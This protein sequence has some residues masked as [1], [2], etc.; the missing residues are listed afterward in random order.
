MNIYS[1][2]TKVNRV[3]RHVEPERMDY[4]IFYLA[5]ADQRFC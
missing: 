1:F 5:T 3:N 2:T 4:E